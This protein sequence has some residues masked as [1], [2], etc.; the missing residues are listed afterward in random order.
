MHSKQLPGIGFQR[1]LVFCISDTGLLD[2]RLLKPGDIILTGS[3]TKLS[4]VIKKFTKGSFSHAI[5]YVGDGSYIHS[6]RNGVHSNNIQRLLFEDESNVMVLRSANEQVI[7]MAC[8]FARSQVGKEYS[9]K[10]AIN[11]KVKAPLSLDNNRQFCSKLVAKAYEFAGLKLVKNADTCMPK[12]IE[13][14]K[15]LKI[16]NNITLK[17]NKDEIEF[18]D[19][20]SPLD[21]QT[22]ATNKI[23]FAARALFK[24][25]IQTLSE[26]PHFLFQ[27]PQFDSQ[28]SKV[29]LETDYLTLWDNDR[30]K[31]P[32]RYDLKAFCNLPITDIEKYALAKREFDSSKGMLKRFGSMLNFYTDAHEKHNLQFTKLHKD[33]YLKLYLGISDNHKVA[34]SYLEQF[35]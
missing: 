6:D 31:N 33:L 18:A 34:S 27:K 29:I 13:E 4:R 7:S 9:V 8:D 5:L 1:R 22:E 23:L 12:E 26:L 17:A 28:L 21:R 25:D 24:N 35:S 16:V 3:D 10:G 19:S 30:V 14:S 32:W 11:A 2:M 15:Y 20:D